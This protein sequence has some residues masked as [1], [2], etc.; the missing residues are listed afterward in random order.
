M[1]WSYLQNQFWNVVKR[2]FKKGLIINNFHIAAL[3]SAKAANPSDADID[4]MLNRYNPLSIAVNNSYSTWKNLGGIQEANTLNVEQLI[5]TLPERLN[6]WMPPIETKF[7]KNT[8]QFKAIFPN[9][10]SGITR[11]G[12]DD[13]VVAV[14][15]LS[16]SLKGDTDL[17]A[18]KTLVDAF[19]GLLDAARG[20]QLGS[21][22]SNNKGSESVGLALEN[23]MLMQY[24]NLGL[25]MDKYADKPD[26][27]ASF[28]DLN[29]IR[30]ST[31]TS[32]TGTLDPSENEAV[33]IH[34]FMAGDELRL[35]IIG[36][37]AA[38]FYLS[39]AANGTNSTAIEVK[40]NEEL[41]IEVDDFKVADYSTH[42]Y[43]TVVNSSNSI[44]TKYEA[45]VL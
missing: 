24:R 23:A 30:E 14:K 36:N 10:R 44:T 16:Q 1:I 35:K 6:K 40:A 31:Q 37:A 42:R 12:I 28:F 4:K 33:L 18:T 7:A 8:P 41:I 32:F 25:L 13:K 43:L 20:T 3:Q 39:N 9:G 15:N 17:A 45:E 2:N 11:G 26:T 34:T 29:T 27:I 21:K 5:A 19:V 22:S 38:N